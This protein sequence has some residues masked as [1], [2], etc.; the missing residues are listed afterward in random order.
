VT[1]LN[2]VTNSLECECSTLSPSTIVLDTLGIFKN[3]DH[4]I[5]SLNTIYKITDYAWYESPVIY[6]LV[7][8]TAIFLILI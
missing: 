2:P 7:F 4:Y 5:F 6:I 8:K 1:V 3:S